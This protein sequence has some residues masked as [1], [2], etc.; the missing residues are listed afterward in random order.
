MKTLVIA[1]SILVGGMVQA[2]TLHKAP[3]KNLTERLVCSVI[4]R[5][6][7]DQIRL[8]SYS[9]NASVKLWVGGISSEGGHYAIFLSQQ[10]SPGLTGRTLARI[11]QFSDESALKQMNF[12]KVIWTS[13]DTLSVGEFVKETV[14]ES[15]IVLHH[16]FGESLQPTTLVCE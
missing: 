14:I 13:Q 5:G 2:K 7:T 6:L 11:F 3:D 16:G 12:S 10:S 4:S 8:I 1:F 15:R 9:E